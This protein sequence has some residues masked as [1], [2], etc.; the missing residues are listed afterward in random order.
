MQNGMLFS[1]MLSHRLVPNP[2][3]NG[4]AYVIMSEN[5]YNRDVEKGL[6][7]EIPKNYFPDDDPTQRPHLQ[8]RAHCNT[9]YS[10]WLNYYVYQVTPYEL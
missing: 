6:P 2:D 3:P 9:L 5:E 10:N 4:P 1:M 8:W 7:I